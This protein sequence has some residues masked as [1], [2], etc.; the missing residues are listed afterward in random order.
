MD[1]TQSHRN[2]VGLHGDRVGNLSQRTMEREVR[3]GRTGARAERMV[4]AWRPTDRESD[5]RALGWTHEQVNNPKT[6]T[7][8]RCLKV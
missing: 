2:P 8:L 4:Q 1:W 7:S 3:S 6:E 5:A